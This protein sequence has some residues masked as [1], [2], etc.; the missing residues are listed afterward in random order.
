MLSRFGWLVK[1][2]GEGDG[3]AN[4]GEGAGDG[5]QKPAEKTFTQK[6]LDDIIN[7]RFAK[8]RTE[9]EKLLTEL[10]TLRDKAQLTAE[11][12]STLE[13]Q[14]TTLTESLQTKEQ[15]AAAALQ[16]IQEKS[17]KEIET[18]VSE[19][20]IWKNR[21]VDSTIRR[22][23]TD[24]AVSSGALEPS[25]IVMMFG[26]ATAIEEVMDSSGKPTGEFIT[27][28]KFQGIDPETKKPAQLRLPVGEAL[29]H[30]R[31][32]G[33]HKNL[34]KAAGTA[35]TGQ[36]GNGRGGAKDSNKMPNPADYTNPADFQ[37]A[38]Q[39]WRNTHNVDGT[40][41]ESKK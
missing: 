2:Y 3:Q 8:E 13:G 18:A 12:R 40:P 25:Q 16:K 11:E 5:N 20:D 14:I 33:L 21:F 28:M 15:Q 32:N 37:T 1:F 26:S 17:K 34:F 41:I 24:A 4:E 23:L 36:D 7:K 19:R 10:T 39:T 35:G 9:R 38:Y 27:L 22:S 29:Q 30:M 6:Q 31:D